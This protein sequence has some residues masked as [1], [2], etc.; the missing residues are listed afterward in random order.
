MDPIRIDVADAVAP[1]HGH[2]RR[3]RARSASPLLDEPGRR[4]GALSCRA[5]SYGGCTAAARARRAR[6]ANPGA[7]RRALQAARRRVAHLRRAGPRERRSRSDAHHLR[8]RRH[9]RH[10]RFCGRHLSSRHRARP[11]ADDAPRAGGQRDRRQGRR[12]PPAR[13]EP[14]R[15]LPSASRRDCRSVGARHAAAARIPRRA[16]RGDQVRHDVEPGA[17]RPHRARAE[18]DLR[19]RSRSADA[20]HRRVVP[21]QGGRVVSADERE[22]GPRRDPELRPHRRPRASRP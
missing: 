19:A 20:D 8:R 3:R 13:Q 16:V 1:L 12:Q 2:A 4:R 11:C 18:G 21:D 22:A 6:R 7:R 10:G 15:L 14:D 17:L 5:R 9:R